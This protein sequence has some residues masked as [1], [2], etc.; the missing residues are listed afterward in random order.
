MS[1]PS[2]VVS[3]SLCGST[4]AELP[5]TWIRSVELGVEKLYCDRC[6]RANLRSME[7]RLDAEWF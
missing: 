6:S 7:S 5:L 3:C 4:A 2:P 1:G